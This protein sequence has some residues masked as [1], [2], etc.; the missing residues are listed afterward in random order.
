MRPLGRGL[1]WAQLSRVC[2]D[3]AYRVRRREMQ[4]RAYLMADAD[5]LS[6]PSQFAVPTQLVIAARR[7]FF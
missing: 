6:R 7:A 1:H 3:W 4:A 2:D 5:S